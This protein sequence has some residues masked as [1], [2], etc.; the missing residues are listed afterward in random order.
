[1]TTPTTSAGCATRSGA[2]RS[3]SSLSGDLTYVFDHRSVSRSAGLRASRICDPGL[4]GDGIFSTPLNTT[5]SLTGSSPV[6]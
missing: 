1:M 5:N 3:G 2:T 6:A 4:P